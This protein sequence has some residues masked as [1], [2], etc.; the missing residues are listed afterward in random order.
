[1]DDGAVAAS[2]RFNQGVRENGFG[3]FV[4]DLSWKIAM[5]LPQQARDSVPQVSASRLQNIRD[6]LRQDSNYQADH[7]HDQAQ[8]YKN[9][10][11][12][13]HGDSS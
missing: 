2:R 6:C 11:R 10:D 7:K 3:N 4:T 8:T 9:V 1:M 12:L 5:D 13:Q